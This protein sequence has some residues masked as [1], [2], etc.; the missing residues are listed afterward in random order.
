VTRAFLPQLIAD[1]SGRIINMSSSVGWDPQSTNMVHYAT[2]K[3]G[4]VGFTR[5]LAGEL[6]RH[7]IT[8]N[9]LAPGLVR[10]NALQARLPSEQ[11]QRTK[12]RQA[13][14]R[15]IET[16]DVTAA[17]EYLVSPAA[18]AVTGIVLPVNGGRVWL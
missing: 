7:G 17:V 4:V 14:P 3:L 12:V 1:G 8:V 15:T 2:S 11:W 16:S 9:C 5:S 6:G 13:I 10:T 18:A